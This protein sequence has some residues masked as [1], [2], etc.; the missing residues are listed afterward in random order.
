MSNAE[1]KARCCSCVP[2]NG[3]LQSTATS[4]LRKQPWLLKSMVSRGQ[5]LKA[6]GKTFKE[7][8][9]WMG[10]Q[11]TSVLSLMGHGQK[12]MRNQWRG[13]EGRN[14]EGME[15]I[16]NLSNIYRMTRN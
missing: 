8:P 4:R 14:H 6:S 5:F 11:M 9:G 16:R 3:V 1:N 2:A 7:K 10:K 12:P 13:E 15:K